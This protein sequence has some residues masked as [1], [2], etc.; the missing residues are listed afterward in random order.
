MKA[1][2]E[3]RALANDLGLTESDAADMELKA[4]LY[5]KAAEAILKSK[6]NYEEIAE[7]LGVSKLKINRIANISEY[8]LSIDLLKKI[9]SGL[10]KKF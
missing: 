2:K 8:G 4:K 5:R 10:E 7:E 6:L 3:A 1:S 9:I